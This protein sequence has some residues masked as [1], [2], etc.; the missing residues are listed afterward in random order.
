[1][2]RR[3][4]QEINNQV[5]P[6]LLG[7]TLEN[8]AKQLKKLFTGLALYLRVTENDT[9]LDHGVYYVSMGD[10]SGVPV[11]LG[12]T[13]AQRDSTLRRDAATSYLG[14]W[15]FLALLEK[16]LADLKEIEIRLPL[17]SQ[18]LPL[19]S[20]Q[21][22]NFRS[23]PER[24]RQWRDVHAQV[25]RLSDQQMAVLAPALTMAAE[26]TV[27]GINDNVTIISMILSAVPNQISD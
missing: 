20:K 15:R 19:T 11:E 25:P 3:E 13:P 8:E 27:D 24:V 6:L 5:Q 22:E 16:V 21:R 9:T 17:N 12:L 10:T 18:M 2:N 26:H 7:E 1:M 4:L 14:I 23:P